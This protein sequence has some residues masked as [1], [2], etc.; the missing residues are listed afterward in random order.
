MRPNTPRSSSQTA[1]TRH[2]WGGDAELPA[3][4][5]Q[6]PYKRSSADGTDNQLCGADMVRE[7]GELVSRPGPCY[8]TDDPADVYVDGAGRQHLWIVYR[9]GRWY[10][11]AVWSQ[12]T[13]GYGTYTFVTASPVDTID[14][15][16]VAAGFT[17]DDTSSA[18]SHREIDVEFSRLGVAGGPN[19]QYVL[20]PYTNLEHRHQFNL[21][22]GGRSATHLF[23]WAPGQVD[24][25]SYAGSAWHPDPA[26]LLY[27][28]SHADTDVP[29]P[30]R[31]NMRFNLWLFNGALP[32]NGQ[33]IEFI[34]SS[35]GFAPAQ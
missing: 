8:Y 15:N 14:R 18:Y 11:A 27:S 24:W 22:L 23:T 26:D 10:C 34:I 5:F 13:F 12:A 20:Q 28:Y 9:N 21:S 29:P 19:A 25:A 30:S 1:T 32:S 33:A 2:R 7:G 31:A 17:Y 4:L 3:E 16:A 35:F 6:F